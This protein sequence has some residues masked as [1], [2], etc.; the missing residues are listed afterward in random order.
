MDEVGGSLLERW[1]HSDPEDQTEKKTLIAVEGPPSSM[2]E[3][4][5]I[6]VVHIIA[7]KGN[8]Q[9]VISMCCAHTAYFALRSWELLGRFTL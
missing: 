8:L 6:T 7:H 3:L 9:P 5:E 4:A 1:H 2:E